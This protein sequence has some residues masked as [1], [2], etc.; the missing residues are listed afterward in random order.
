MAQ[1]SPGGRRLDSGRMAQK[2]PGLGAGPCG[3]RW[4]PVVAAS[5]GSGSGCAGPLPKM[6][7]VTL[8]EIKEPVPCANRSGVGGREDSLG[9][10]GSLAATSSRG[11]MQSP[12]RLEATWSAL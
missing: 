4:N 1:K 2:S 11:T 6:S 3:G 10:G 12:C 7:W 9:N 5:V 8:G